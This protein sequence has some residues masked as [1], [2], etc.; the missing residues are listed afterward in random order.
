MSGHPEVVKNHEAR[1]EC[2]KSTIQEILFVITTTM[3]IAM[4][5]FLLGAVTVITADVG[6]DLN[7]TTAE[8]SWISA[9]SGLSSGAFLLSFGRF[10]DL[11]GRKYL[12]VGSL[13]L[14]AVFAVGAGFSNDALTLDILNGV[15]GLMSAAAV[16]PAQGSLGTVYEYPSK[17]KNAAFACFS[18]GNPLGFV[19]GMV[20]SGIFAQVFNWR[21]SFFML[22][23]I[24]AV[25]TVLAIF[26]MPPDTT[27][28][29]EFS[30]ETMKEFDVVGTGLTIA[31]IGM[32]SAG[33]SLGGDAPQGWKTPYVL[34]LI[35]LGFLFMVGF[36]PWENHFKSPLVPMRIFRD[37]NLSWLLIILF[38][39]YLAFS[40]AVFWVSLYIQ[41]VWNT[42]PLKVAVY[43]LPMAITGIIVNI[44]AG[45]LLHKVSNRLLMGI[46][47]LSYAISFLLWALHKTGDSYWAFLFPGLT[48]CVVG[49]DL[50]F[51]VANM[52]VMSSL[53]KDQQSIAGSIFQTI[54]KLCVAIGMGAATAIFD[55]L[56]SSPSSSGY[57]AN[58]PVEPYAGIF[59]FATASSALSVLFVPFLTLKT[60]GH[61]EVPVEEQVD[62]NETNCTAG[63]RRSTMS[64]KD[65]G[66]ESVRE[67]ERAITESGAAEK[68]LAAQLS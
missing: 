40:I 59:W 2:F 30:L 25:I 9:S 43:L 52:Y 48:L 34:V 5:S 66:K 24:Y 64:T 39:G 68:K 4:T 10:A 62:A 32:F 55:G 45:L 36:V 37:R 7:M 21:A 14:F 31:G 6:E 42:P 67:V 23:I 3:A 49:A 57:H 11:F 29:R 27:L 46:G 41:R 28:R 44:A 22:A 17:R 20:F 33:L 60:Q 50:E 54:T 51:N 1:P 63:S 61:V 16:P 18:A 53:P 56:E 47:A 58:D 19:F 38:L 65:E 15:M 12:F 13:G 26:T 35:I 8:I